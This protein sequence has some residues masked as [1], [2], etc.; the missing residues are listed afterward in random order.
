[1]KIEILA[2]TSP[3]QSALPGPG[4]SHDLLGLDGSRVEFD[5]EVRQCIGDSVCDDYGWGNRASLSDTFD[6]ERIQGRRKMEML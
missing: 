4:R 2:A 1:M 6:T 3:M 5:L